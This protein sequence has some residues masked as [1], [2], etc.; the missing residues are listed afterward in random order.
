MTGIYLEY[1]IAKGWT[2][3]A[4][5]ILRTIVDPSIAYMGI[6]CFI[7]L[8]SINSM[9][10]TNLL[11]IIVQERN[12]GPLTDP[13]EYGNL[14]T[15][16]TTI[17]CLLCTPFFLYAGLMMRRIKREKLMSGEENI[18]DENKKASVYMKSL[19]I[20]ENGTG[21]IAEPKTHNFDELR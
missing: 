13:A 4:M 1:F 2:S 11:A 18:V 5:Y 20:A 12:I 17:P 6:S 8:T 19:T 7:V 16:F 21:I 9:F 15:C 3:G 14:V 10:T